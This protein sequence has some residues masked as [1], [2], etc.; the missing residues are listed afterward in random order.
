MESG[1][2]LRETI[3]ATTREFLMTYQDGAAH[4]D[5]SIISRNLSP[6]CSRQIAP[7]SFMKSVGAPPDLQFSNDA[8]QSLFEKDLEASAVLKSDILNLTIDAHARKAAARTVYHGKFTDGEEMSM[9]FAWFLDFNDDGTK[10]THIVEVVDPPES[11]KFSSKVEALRGKASGS[12][13]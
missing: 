3:E 9:E 4:K 8:Y 2:K 13:S 5:P 12:D 1:N 7:A 10:V 11:L 6:D